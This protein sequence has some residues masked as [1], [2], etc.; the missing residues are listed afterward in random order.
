[1]DFKFDGTKL[2]SKGYII[3][4]EG[5][6][7]EN[8]PTST[9]MYDVIK[10]S[11]SDVSHK[12]SHN[13]ESNYTVTFNIMKDP[14]TYDDTFLTEEDVS[15]MTR[16]L[17]RKQYKIFKYIDDEGDDYPTWYNVQNTVE[18]IITGDNIVG[19]AVTVNANAPYG[20]ADETEIT[21]SGTSA[22]ITVVSDEEGYIY[23]KLVITC[24]A[25]GDLTITNSRENSR[26]TTINNV[27]NGEVITITGGDVLQISSSV[28]GHDL[29]T[30]FNYVFPRL[31]NTFHSRVNTLTTNLSSSKVLTYNGI[32]KVGL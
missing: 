7:E 23:P 32:R 13:Y 26:V 6:L 20:F 17:V 3:Y 19:L 16:W 12:V 5:L 22:E 31:L 4:H 28:S 21:W 11:L 29:A 18:K 25:A 9:M 2:S 8:R 14:C 15:T 1:M 10:A 24:N 30:D 27:A